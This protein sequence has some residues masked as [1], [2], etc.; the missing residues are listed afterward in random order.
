VYLTS[1]ERDL[2]C[3][4]FDVLNGM[5]EPIYEHHLNHSRPTKFARSFTHKRIAATRALFED[6]AAGAQS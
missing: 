5:L 6:K 4:A 2:V 1:A 3:Q